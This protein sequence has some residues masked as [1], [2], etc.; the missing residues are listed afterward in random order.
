M[1]RAIIQPAE[2]V[3]IVGGEH[4]AGIDARGI[5][6]GFR[7]LVDMPDTL[8]PLEF[9]AADGPPEESA[10]WWADKKAQIKKDCGQAGAGRV[11]DVFRA[12]R[13]A[14]SDDG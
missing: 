2:A 8:G 9:E 3:A 11:F 1:I 12:R 10:Q 5:A 4:F 7:N 6:E 14:A 13:K